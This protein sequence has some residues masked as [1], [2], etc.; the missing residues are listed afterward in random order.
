MSYWLQDA[1]GYVGDV[2]SNAGI[3]ELRSAAS[4]PALHRFLEIGGARTSAE[5]ADVLAECRAS[6]NDA[7]RSFGD[8]LALVKKHPV[9]LTDGTHALNAVAGADGAERDTSRFSDWDESTIE[10]LGEQEELEPV[11]APVVGGGS[12]AVVYERDRVTA[13]FDA[14]GRSVAPHFATIAKVWT[15]GADGGT[16]L[17]IIALDSA[18]LAAAAE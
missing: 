5:T 1:D 10:I 7:V 11:L 13:Y 12:N 8:V 18:E 9:V 4:T 3:I 15:P 6:N 16:V 17:Q 2:A 14:T